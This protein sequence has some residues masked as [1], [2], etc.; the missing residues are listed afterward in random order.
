MLI[1]SELITPA[2]AEQITLAE[3]KQHL[4]VDH[5]DED[6][7]ITS[8]IGIARDQAEAVCNRRFGTQSW[9]LYYDKFDRIKLHGCG[10]VSTATVYWRDD[11]GNWIELNSVEYEVV[12]AVPAYVF[13]RDDFN[14]PTTG[15]FGEV[16][17]VD[18][19]CGQPAPLGVKAWMLLRI[20]TLFENREMDAERVVQPQ[21][22]A[23]SL[24]TAYRVV[25]FS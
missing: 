4:R 5:S 11:D 2:S 19:T 14:L 12:K 18:V 22:F 1:R 16:V 21:D 10:V 9:K 23:Q 17:R 24:L 13:Y 7:Y 6:S 3:A 20:G 15:D 8:L 25:D